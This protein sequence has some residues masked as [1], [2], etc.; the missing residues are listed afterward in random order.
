ML[1]KLPLVEVRLSGEG[2]LVREAIPQDFQIDHRIMSISTYDQWK[3]IY[4]N[5]LDFDV[6]NGDLSGFFTYVKDPLM[7]LH[8]QLQRSPDNVFDTRGCEATKY[9]V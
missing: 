9:P 1:L 8:Y 3:L 6:L 7:M 4:D 5:I 2:F